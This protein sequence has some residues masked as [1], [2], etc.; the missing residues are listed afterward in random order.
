MVRVTGVVTGEVGPIVLFPTG[1]SQLFAGLRVL[2]DHLLQGRGGRADAHQ[3]LG[4]PMQGGHVPGPVNASVEALWVGGVTGLIPVRL[5]V[6]G[7][8]A[9]LHAELVAEIGDPRREQ[10][11]PTVGSRRE[12]VRLTDY[13][14][15][16]QGLESA[17]DLLWVGAAIESGHHAV[18][19][20]VHG[21]GRDDT[22]TGGHPDDG[23]ATAVHAEQGVRGP[24]PRPVELAR[25]GTARDGSAGT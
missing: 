7:V 15:A 19:T 4:E 14:A 2:P 22:L 21:V 13:A 24:G 8:R 11:R 3:V 25:R 16:S 1:P 9:R 10:L 6:S 17:E 5:L 23:A 12:S 18:P 20:V